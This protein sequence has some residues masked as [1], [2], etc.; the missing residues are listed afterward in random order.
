VRSPNE[1]AD[2]LARLA[3]I[4][5]DLSM[6]IRERSGDVGCPI[7]DIDITAS[8]LARRATV[9]LVDIKQLARVRGRG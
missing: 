6:Y 4:A 9:L 2:E 8:G 5:L 7:G 1:I 3:S